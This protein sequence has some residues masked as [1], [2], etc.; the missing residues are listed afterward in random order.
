MQETSCTKTHCSR[1]T[2]L[3]R[4]AAQQIKCS[5]DTALYDTLLNNAV[6]NS[7]HVRQALC[8]TGTL[9]NRQAAQQSPN[10]SRDFLLDNPVQQ[11][12]CS[13]EPLLSKKARRYSSQQILCP[14]DTLLNRTSARQEGLLNGHL[15]NEE[16]AQ[17]T[18]ISIVT[19]LGRLCARRPC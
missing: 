17:Q 10:F 13:T 6:L 4:Q 9:L 15:L 1:A 19:V 12:F 8:S 5:T 2:Q 18:P 14:T 16:S 7:L 3:H 11:S